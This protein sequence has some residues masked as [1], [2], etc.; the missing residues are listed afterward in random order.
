M[1]GAWVLESENLG[2]HL[3]FATNPLNLG[4]RSLSCQLST[5]L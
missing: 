4:I 1:E 3:I 5:C 2:L